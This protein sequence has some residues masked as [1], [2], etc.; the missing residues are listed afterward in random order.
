MKH[1]KEIVT[2]AAAYNEDGRYEDAISLLD[3]SSEFS[4]AFLSPKEEWYLNF[5]KMYIYIEALLYTGEV[6][7]AKQ[8]TSLLR[9]HAVNGQERFGLNKETDQLLQFIQGI[10]PAFDAD[11]NQ[12]EIV[13]SLGWLIYENSL[14]ADLKGQALYYLAQS[15]YREN[16]VVDALNRLKELPETAPSSFTRKVDELRKQIEQRMLLHAK[17][18]RKEHQVFIEIGEKENVWIIELQHNSQGTMLA[19]MYRDGILKLLNAED[20]AEIV[21][22]EDNV[23]LYREEKAEEVCLAFSPDSRYLAVGLGVGIV[24]LECIYYDYRDGGDFI[25]K[26]GKLYRY[27]QGTY[28]ILADS[29]QE[30][31]ESE[32]VKYGLLQKQKQWL[33]KTVYDSDISRWLLDNE[34]GLTEIK[35]ASGAYIKWWKSSDGN[36]FIHEYDK[37]RLG[38]ANAY[39]ANTVD[40]QRL[41]NNSCLSIQGFPFHCYYNIEAKSAEIDNVRERYYFNHQLYN[42]CDYSRIQIKQVEG[43]EDIYLS[44]LGEKE[45]MLRQPVSDFLKKL[46]VL[47]LPLTDYDSDLV[48]FAIKQGD[49]SILKLISY[50]TRLEDAE[51]T[52]R[53]TVAES[54]VDM[55][56]VS[57]YFRRLVQFSEKMGI[58][59]HPLFFHPYEAAGISYELTAEDWYP[60]LKEIKLTHAQRA[61][62][63]TLLYM[64]LAQEGNEVAAKVYPIYE[65]LLMFYILGGCFRKGHGFIDVGTYSFHQSGWQSMAAIQPIDVYSNTIG[66]YKKRYLGHA[67]R[68]IGEINWVEKKGELSHFNGNS[69]SWWIENVGAAPA[70]LFKAKELNIDYSPNVFSLCPDMIRVEG[71]LVQWICESYLQWASLVDNRNPEAMKNPCLYDPFIELFRNENELAVMEKKIIDL[72]HLMEKEPM[73]SYVEALKR[74]K[75]SL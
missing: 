16:N 24:K 14:P 5:R 15:H 51:D 22:F 70:F 60:Q 28:S 26:D 31:L 69:L 74:E 23:P 34:L 75:F 54:D 73:I 40:L 44:Y 39:V 10:I 35:E 61:C 41:Y 27:I 7:E 45:F 62:K 68:K 2:Q 42:T 47:S 59:T 57:E 56:Y 48:D 17:E 18:P 72:I 32:A 20:G 30:F 1:L 71:T 25:G 8:V 55:L 43:P 63:Y 29:V 66:T 67:V 50:L 9:Q 64:K 37:E 21:S 65:P 49:E 36:I 4:R 13:R 58:K 3:P 46:P 38:N 12:Y 33:V 52:G 53:R 19:V 11:Q 6:A